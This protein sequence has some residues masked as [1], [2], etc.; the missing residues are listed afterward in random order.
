[1]GCD[2][3]SDRQLKRRLAEGHERR[4]D[5]A[6]AQDSDH[7]DRATLAKASRCPTMFRLVPWHTVDRESSD[8]KNG[9]EV[10]EIGRETPG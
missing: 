1:V 4:D 10:D 6:D 7:Q 5:H 2:D 9:K 8:E 3:V